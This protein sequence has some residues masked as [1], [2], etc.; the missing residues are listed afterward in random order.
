MK[1]VN[2]WEQVK[3]ASN[4]QQLPKGGYVCRIMNG[5]I[6]TFNGKNGPFDCLE[7]SIDV[8]EGEFKDFYATD[9]RGQNQEDKK[10]RGV[11][12]LYV[13]KDDGSDMDEWTKSKLKAATNAVEDSNQGYHWD[14]NEAG[15]KGKLVGCL[16]RNEE[17]EYN[18][19]TG[20]KTKP[21]KFV[22]VFDIRN[23]KFE[24]PNDKPLNK[25]T[26]DSD[27]S[28]TVS[29]NAGIDSYLEDLPF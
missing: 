6:K 13:P 16:I 22:P 27:D 24:I 11:L 1:P 17:W 18:G 2:N 29:T 25:K 3:A 20:W 19:K 28:E 23:G 5:E 8:S 9:Y 12:R 26:S 15:L 4:R 21:F 10:W 14:W 7:I